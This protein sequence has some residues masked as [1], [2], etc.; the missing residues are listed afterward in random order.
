MHFDP[1]FIYHVSLEQEPCIIGPIHPVFYKSYGI[2]QADFDFTMFDLIKAVLYMGM[3]PGM[4][5]AKSRKAELEFKFAMVNAA[6]DDEQ[7][8][9]KPYNYRFVRMNSVFIA[10]LDPTEKAAIH[11]WIGM[12][13]ATLL[14]HKKFNYK[15]VIHYSHFKNDPINSVVLKDITSKLSPDLICVKG[16][17]EYGVFEAKGMDSI[18]SDTMLHAIEQLE[19]IRL[20]N[21]QNPVDSIVSYTRTSTSKLLIRYRDPKEGKENIEFSLAAALIW[22]YTP[23]VKL[24]EELSEGYRISDYPLI[25][26][27]LPKGFTLNR[28]FAEKIKQAEQYKNPKEYAEFIGGIHELPEMK[29]E[30]NLNG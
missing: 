25:S 27:L 10:S 1:S 9:K 17:Y 24:Q 16:H 23:L 15:Y 14:A 19:Q 22:Q 20:V 29:F 13:F 11:Y 21:G 8:P 4:I 6:L 12:I 18:R 5:F 28:F 26:E 30:W 3:K 2:K 7:I